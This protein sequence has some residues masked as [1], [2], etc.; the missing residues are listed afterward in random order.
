MLKLKVSKKWTLAKTNFALCLNY[1]SCIPKRQR[2]TYQFS[3]S[4]HTYY[5]FCSKV[6]QKV[7]FIAYTKLGRQVFHQQLRR[8]T[9]RHIEMLLFNRCTSLHGLRSEAKKLAGWKPFKI[10]N[11]LS[12]WSISQSIRH[13]INVVS[14]LSCNLISRY[15]M[16]SFIFTSSFTNNNRNEVHF[17]LALLCHCPCM[18]N[19]N[20]DAFPLFRTFWRSARFFSTQSIVKSVVY[21][22][23]SRAD[24]G[25]QRRGF[26]I[27]TPK[28]IPFRGS[29]CN[30]S[31]KINIEVPG[32]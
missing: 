15:A 12:K 26:K 11:T 19:I 29:G 10:P 28:G 9:V 27:Q 23:V 13:L 21:M 25:F 2:N 32:N 17:P 8:S 31:W 4:F 16:K 30:L 24:T 14:K 18:P 5:F 7:G 1:F 22:A 3:S 20:L 6:F